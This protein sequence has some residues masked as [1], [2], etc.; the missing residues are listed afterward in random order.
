MG[1][2]AFGLPD[3]SSGVWG[4]PPTAPGVK[5]D[6]HPRPGAAGESIIKFKFLAACMVLFGMANGRAPSVSMRVVVRYRP[7][8][9]YETNASFTV[10]DHGPPFDIQSPHTIHDKRQNKH[11]DRCDDSS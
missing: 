5:G 8:K 1:G 10:S 9:D 3:V 2:L 7:N 11:Y 4:P 6:N